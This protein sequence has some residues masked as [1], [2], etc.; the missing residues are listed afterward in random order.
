M[1]MRKVTFEVAVLKATTE[2]E[3]NYEIQAAVMNS[4]KKLIG[5]SAPPGSILTTSLEVDV[6]YVAAP[7][8]YCLSLR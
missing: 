4:S 6:A 2:G 1:M 5:Y 8:A 3:F 7:R